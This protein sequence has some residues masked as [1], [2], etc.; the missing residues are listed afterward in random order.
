MLLRQTGIGMRSS[1]FFLIL[2]LGSPLPVVE[3]AAS[4][5]EEAVDAVHRTAKRGTRHAQPAP[6]VLQAGTV[7]T[8]ARPKPAAVAVLLRPT[9]H[10]DVALA[11]TRPPPVN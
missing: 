8:P 10:Y 7:P 1:L 3:A 2:A 6:R 4:L 5:E 9:P 11:F